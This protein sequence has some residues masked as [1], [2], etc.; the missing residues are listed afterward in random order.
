[1]QI[2]LRVA[3]AADIPAI[4]ELIPLSVH[5]LQAEHYTREQREGALG[6]VFGVDT[7]LIGDGT[8][9][10]AVAGSQIV[11]CG[12]WSKR[13]TLFGSDAAKRSEDALLDPRYDAARIRAFFVHPQWARRGIGTKIMAACEQAAV[14]AGFTRLDLVATLTGE[15]LYRVHGFEVVERYEVPLRNGAALPVIRMSKR[16]SAPAWRN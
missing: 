10:V 6:S 12:G 14:Q 9:L 7:Q 13:Q 16:V 1:M 8:Y 3:F 11:G 4:E 2:D 5:G 15:S